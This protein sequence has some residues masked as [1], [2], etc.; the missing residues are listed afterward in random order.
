MGVKAWPPNRGLSLTP[1]LGS[2]LTSPVFEFWTLCCWLCWRFY[3]QAWKIKS[4]TIEKKKFYT[5]TKQL[6]GRKFRCFSHGV[7]NDN[8]LPNILLQ[9]DW[10]DINN[11]W[12]CCSYIHSLKQNK[13]MHCLQCL[14]PAVAESSYTPSQFI[15]GVAIWKVM[16]H[17]LCPSPKKLLCICK[18]MSSLPAS[19]NNYLFP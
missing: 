2:S 14:P 5:V 4:A 15:M 8:L 12:K 19:K 7:K 16:P 18:S 6:F 9:N 17:P 11:V 13:N 3:R 10:Y 1:L